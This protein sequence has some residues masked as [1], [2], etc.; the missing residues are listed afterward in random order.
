[1]DELSLIKI[2]SSWYTDEEIENAKSLL[3][4][5]AN[6]KK[7]VRKGE[8]KNANNIIDIIKVIKET[9]QDKL[10]SFVAK[11]LSKIPP[12]TFDHLDVSSVLKTMAAM[13][14][15]IITMKSRFEESISKLNDEVI[16]LKHLNCRNK[17]V[18]H[19]RILSARSARHESALATRSEDYVTGTP[20]RVE[21][22]FELRNTPAG[23][24]N[25]SEATQVSHTAP[26]MGPSYRDVMLSTNSEALKRTYDDENDGY[27][28]V[29]Y[30]R[31]RPRLAERQQNMTKKLPTQ[32]KTII[33][34][35]RG[36][37]VG[38]TLKAADHIVQIYVSRFQNDCSQEDIESYM[39]DNGQNVFSV[40]M[41][42]SK[43][44]TNF[45][46]FK[47]SVE[48]KC[49]DTILREDFWPD[50]IVFRTYKNKTSNGSTQPQ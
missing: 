8:K 49:L 16:D 38:A 47:I 21:N 12:V 29:N 14:T 26:T 44:A 48:K 46:S 19:R 1:M 17:G 22:T 33:K 20:T 39:K 35:R 31:K 5:A 13:Q 23:L 43:N 36:T 42:T 28:T 11:D 27:Q 24:R 40:E 7:T 34:N 4:E 18:D 30:A 10:P 41:L 50:G 3:C 25:E 2:C 9:E 6:A 15:E 32:N 45:K 37:N